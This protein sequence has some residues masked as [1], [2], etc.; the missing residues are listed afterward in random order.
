MSKKIFSMIAVSCAIIVSAASLHAQE[1]SGGDADVI[2]KSK[3]ASDAI[4]ITGRRYESSVLKE[5]KSVTVITEEEIKSSGK[6]DVSQVLETVPGISISREG[7]EGG[8]AYIFMRGSEGCNVLVMIDGVKIG[9]PSSTDSRFDF[10]LIKTESIERIEIV[11]GSM[12]SLYGSEASGGVINIITKKGEG[13]SVALKFTGGMYNSFSQSVTVSE[14]GEKG[15]FLFTGS[16]Y[17][18]GGISTEKDMTGAGGFDDDTTEQYAASCKM[19]GKIWDKTSLMFSMNYSDKNMD[20]DGF[21][22][23]DSDD[24]AANRL[25]T[26][27][28]EFRHSPFTWWDYRAGVSFM[29]MG[30]V[31]EF[32]PDSTATYDSSILHGQFLNRFNVPVVGTLSIGVETIKESADTTYGSLFGFTFLDKSATTSSV[33]IHDAFSLND[34]LFLNAGARLDRHTEF[35]NHYTWDVSG[36]FI[37]PVTGTK[38]RGSAGSAFRAPNLYQ[39]YDGN[40][41]NTDLKP[42][43][44]FVYDAGLYHEIVFAENTAAFEGTY[45]HQTYRDMIGFTSAYDNIDGEI[46]I[47]G[48]ELASSLKVS[49]IVSLSYAYTYLDF[50]ENS[51]GQHFL[52]RPGHKH[53]AILNLTPFTGLGMNLSYNY[54]GSRNGTQAIKLDPYHKI[55]ANIRYSFNETLTITLRG[56]NLTDADYMDTYGYNTYGR[57]FFGGV[58]LTF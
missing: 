2:T 11:R 56:E 27:A 43:T 39:L 45:F 16:H 40:Y 8:L 37:V 10:S 4:I 26:T 28:G 29:S 51:G 55:D 17:T 21:A 33:Y 47:Q 31:Y 52:K 18:S 30:R 23:D 12:S 24:K 53:S 36:A 35:G 38:I 48:I 3:S 58:E 42:E 20:L 9:D 19:T 7:T 32:P 5:G 49:G 41:G 22:G 25:F 46:K 13:N 54:T 34:M 44:S 1:T 6:D 15:T 14:A 57:S 50:I